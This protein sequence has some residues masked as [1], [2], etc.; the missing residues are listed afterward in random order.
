MSLPPLRYDLI[1]CTFFGPSPGRAGTVVE[2]LFFDISFPGATALPFSFFERF[3]IPPQVGLAHLLGLFYV[4]TLVWF[5]LRRLPVIPPL[6][7]SHQS[8]RVFFH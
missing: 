1:V 5:P 3:S 6:L 8:L 7:F 4:T 2:A